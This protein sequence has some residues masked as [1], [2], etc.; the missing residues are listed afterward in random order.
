MA[1]C[2]LFK[3]ETQTTPLDQVCDVREMDI[4]WK[5]AGSLRLLRY[6]IQAYKGLEYTPGTVAYYSL[7]HL[8]TTDSICAVEQQQEL[9]ILT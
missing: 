8:A 5:P 6:A 1:R 7:K 9:R 2:R 4:L 3:L